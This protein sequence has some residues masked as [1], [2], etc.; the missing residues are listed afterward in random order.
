MHRL[1]PQA[2][3]GFGS[4]SR[5]NGAS[6][7][8]NNNNGSGGR[9]VGS[10]KVQ[11]SRD[12]QVQ[13]T[14]LLAKLL[15]ASDPKTVAQQH[16]SSLDEQFFHIGSAYMQM[17]EKEGN[18]E[19]YNQL[20]SAMTA[21]MEVKQSTLRPEI[22]LLNKLLAA[23]GSLAWRQILNTRQAGE[24]LVMNDRYFFGLLDQMAQDVS[25]QPDHPKKADLQSKLASIKEE[26][27]ARLDSK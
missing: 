8:S 26:A 9:K 3:S 7:S 21:A 23:E 12:T 27:L 13:A 5:S 15:E 2:S 25:K 16:I 4:S 19:V 20:K 10:S 6:S 1:L 14:E 22:Q 11:K 24:Q 18:T 17:A